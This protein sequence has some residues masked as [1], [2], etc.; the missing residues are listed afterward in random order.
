MNLEGG[1]GLKNPMAMILLGETGE[2]RIR[3]KEHE[4]LRDLE[5]W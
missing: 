4:K 2:V 3:G 5:K 1:R